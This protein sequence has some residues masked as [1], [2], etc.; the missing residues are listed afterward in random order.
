MKKALLIILCIVI[1]LVGIATL[2]T[3]GVTMPINHEM[4]L[5]LVAV[6]IMGGAFLVTMII[7]LAFTDL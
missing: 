3:I 4:I 6:G 1:L 2:I 7:M 5:F